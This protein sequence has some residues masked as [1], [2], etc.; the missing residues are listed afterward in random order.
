M[1]GVEASSVSAASNHRKR[2]E[3]VTAQHDN[4]AGVLKLTTHVVAAQLATIRFE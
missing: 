4:A 1:P 2:A 3:V